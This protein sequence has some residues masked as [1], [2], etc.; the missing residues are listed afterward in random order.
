MAQHHIIEVAYLDVEGIKLVAVLEVLEL[1][2]KVL[3]EVQA[4]FKI[5]FVCEV[6]RTEAPFVV[7]RRFV[8]VV[9]VERSSV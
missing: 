9:G 7:P 2:G 4:T 6:V 5:L 1:E 3:Q 8:P